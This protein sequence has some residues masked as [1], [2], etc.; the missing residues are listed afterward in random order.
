MKSHLRLTNSQADAAR[1]R[2][3]VTTFA[4]RRGLLDTDRGRLL[5]ILDELFANVVTH[6]YSKVRSAGQIDVS[7][8]LECDRLTIEFVDDGRGFNPLAVPPVE[9]DLPAAARPI[10][11]IGLAIVRAL[12][13]DI[14][15]T[16]VDNRN[17]LTLVQTIRRPDNDTPK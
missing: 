3:F 14:G 15:Y 13:D 5:V 1:L 17:R 16:R 7:L 8:S 6:G 2:G 9:L 4:D 10:G 11:G 12:V